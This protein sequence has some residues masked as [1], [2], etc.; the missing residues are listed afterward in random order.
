MLFCC[1]LRQHIISSCSVTIW[2]GARVGLTPGPCPAQLAFWQRC[3]DT[4]PYNTMQ[5]NTLPYITMQYQAIPSKPLSS[6]VGILRTLLQPAG[7]RQTNQYIGPQWQFWFDAFLF[8]LM[9]V[10]SLWT[11]LFGTLNINT[12]NCMYNEV[13]IIFFILTR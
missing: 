6:L 10:I 2:V 8:F 7:R 12:K 9:A 5:Y 4:I 1:L 3:F 13:K 11:H